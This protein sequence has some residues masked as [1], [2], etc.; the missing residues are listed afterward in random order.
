MKL[1]SYWR[2]TA[3]YRVRIA[4]NVKKIEYET[5]A[6]HLVKDGGEQLQEDYRS[7]NPQSL[8]PALETASGDVITQ[9]LAIIDYLDEEFPG[10]PLYPKDSIAKAK[11][12]AMALSVACDIHP[13][14]NLRVLKYLKG[15]E[16]N[17]SDVDNWY[18]HWIHKGFVAIEKQLESSHGSF[19][20][21]NEITVADIF[22]VAQ[23][24]NANRFKVTL[25]AYPL[26]LKI[27]GNCMRLKEFIDA[28]P[29]NQPDCDIV[30]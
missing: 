27:N 18:H 21:G 23:V 4:L 14:N 28:A 29:E 11:I 8:V 30:K 12:K 9:S 24:Y 7:V 17:Q 16:L 26:I 22:L 2:S 19:C 6:I 13:L 3:A 25:E 10:N 20:F 5:K 15:L 1:Y